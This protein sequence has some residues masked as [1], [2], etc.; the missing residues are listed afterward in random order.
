MEKSL[1]VG[2][3]RKHDEQNDTELKNLA[4]K[5]KKRATILPPDRMVRVWIKAKESSDDNKRNNK[6]KTEILSR[7]KI[8]SDIKKK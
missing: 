5:V 2:K 8:S 6:K 3:K 4:E 7:N 1:L